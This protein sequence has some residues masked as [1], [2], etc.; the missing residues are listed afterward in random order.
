MS[1]HSHTSHSISIEPI[2]DETARV[3]H[4]AFPKGSLAM[5]LGGSLARYTDEL[6]APLFSPLGQPA[7]APWR[8]ALVSVLQLAEGLS[9]RQAADAVRA[10]LYWKYALG[11]ELT[12]P[13]FHYSVLSEF[14]E[15][16]IEGGLEQQLLDTLLTA[17]KEQGWVQAGGTQRT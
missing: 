15:R 13:G 17:C 1:L 4:A 5:D 12:D 2:P 11:L 9:D 6:F 8:L 7:L 10:R 3:A 16:L 14:R